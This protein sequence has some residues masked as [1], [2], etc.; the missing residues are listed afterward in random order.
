MKSNSVLGF[1]SSSVV[2]NPPANAGD[3]GSIT[4]LEDLLEKEM[5]SHSGILAWKIPWTEEPGVLQRSWTRLSKWTTTIVYYCKNL[6][7]QKKYQQDLKSP[8]TTVK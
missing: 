6:M 5:V 4:R 8:V 3:V 7:I 2:K 1:P